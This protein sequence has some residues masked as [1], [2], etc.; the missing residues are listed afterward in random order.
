MLN[1]KRWQNYILLL[2]N[3][4]LLP[5]ASFFFF[6][7][8]VASSHISGNPCCRFSAILLCFW[9]RNVASYIGYFLS[10][11]PVY[12]VPC[13]WGPVY[14]SSSTLTWRIKELIKAHSSDVLAKFS[15]KNSNFPSHS[16]FLNTYHLYQKLYNL[17]ERK[18]GIANPKV[19]VRCDSR[20]L[21]LKT[22]IRP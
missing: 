2:E 17:P 4:T 6:L 1:Y 7:F 9:R 15:R 8:V 11:T 21:I 22:L 12:N 20:W 10:E 14:D 13:N 16:G 18:V 5:G 19:A 3:I